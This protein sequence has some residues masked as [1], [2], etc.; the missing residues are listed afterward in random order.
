[1]AQ[2]GINAELHGIEELTEFIGLIDLGELPIFYLRWIADTPD[3]TDYLY[4]LYHSAS[5]YNAVHYNNITI[6]NLIEQAWETID[7]TEF[8][9][10]IQQIESTIVDDA[11][12]IYIYH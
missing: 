10:L 12:A 4:A 3:P 9:Q 2:V 8:I 11:P 7:E 6:D 5:I 1:M